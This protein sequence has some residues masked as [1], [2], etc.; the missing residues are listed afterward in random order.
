MSTRPAPRPR[1]RK[2]F[3]SIFP[4]IAFVVIL[5]CPDDEPWRSTLYPTDWVPGYEDA[6]GRFLHDFSYAG[7]HNGEIEPPTTPPGSTYNVLD[8]G[9]DETGST[10]SNAAI[11]AAIDA[12]ET[13]GGGIVHLPAGLYRCDDLLT[14]NASDVVIRGAGPGQTQVY[15]TRTTNMGSRRSLTFSTSLSSGAEYP[16]AEDGENLSFVVKVDDSSG[17][18]VGDDVTVGWVITDDFVEE[19]NMTGTWYSFNGQ[20]KPFFRR[21]VVSVDDTVTPHEVTLDVPLRYPAKLRDQASLRKESGYLSECGIENLALSNAVDWSDAWAFER[22]H[23]LAFQNVKDCWVRNVYSFESPL[24]AGTGYHL[25]SGGVY[26]LSSKRLTVTDCRMEQ[27]QNRGGGGCGYLYE[28]SKSSEVLTRDCVGIRGRHNFIQNWDFGTSG[29]VWLRCESDQGNC[30]SF[31]DDPIGYNCH[32]EYHH[33]LAMACLV[34]QCTIRDGWYGGNRQDWSSGAGITVTQ[35][36]Y[37][38]TDGGGSLRSWQFGWGYIIGTEGM[39][40]NT[41]MLVGDSAEGTEPQ[42]FI[43]GTNTGDLLDPQSLYEDQLDR[44]LS[45]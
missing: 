17:L 43:E 23:V 7:Y 38:N 11:Q 33:S 5:G 37:W 28:I 30:L 1:T 10:D 15:F 4:I 9:A 14:V 27:A 45:P 34:D 29:C 21:Q 35:S 31:E 39:F 42:D 36:A 19:H 18:A 2:I 24:A 32:S 13:A 8:Y 41:G 12:A 25:Q 44:R 6:E 22:V 3:W 16:L 20:W 40:L 26:I